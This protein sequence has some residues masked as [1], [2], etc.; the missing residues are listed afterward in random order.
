MLDKSKNKSIML[1]VMIALIGF[2]STVEIAPRS[3]RIQSDG[4]RYL[5]A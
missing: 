5:T 3:V 1:S 4:F 2:T